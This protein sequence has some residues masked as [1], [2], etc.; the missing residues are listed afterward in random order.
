MHGL[1]VGRV[2]QVGDGARHLQRPVRRTGAP[3]QLGGGRLQEAQGGVVECGMP[4]DRGALQGLVGRALPI[5]GARS[6]RFHPGA[7]GSRGFARRRAQQQ[8]GWQRGHLDVEIDA[9][10]QRS[11]ELALVARHLVGRAAAGTCAGAE[12]AAGAGIH[13]GDQLEARG[14]LGPPRGARDGDGSGLERLAQ[15]LQRGAWKFGQFVEEQHAVVRQRNLAG[16]RRRATADQC[17]R[18]RTV[19]RLARR[20][21][22][23]PRHA[24]ASAQAGDGRAFQRLVDRHGRQQA[25]EAVC[26]HRLARARRPDHEQAVATGRGDLQRALGTGLPLH[27]GQVGVGVG[28]AAGLGL[29]ARPAAAVGRQ[30]LRRLGA[31]RQELRDHV[32]QVPRAVHLGARHQGGLACTVAGQHEPGGDATAVQGQRHGQR[33][34]HRPQLARQGQLAGEFVARESRRIDLTARR[35][36]AHRNRQIEAPRVLG[37]V[38]W[39]QVDRDPL[40]VRKLQARVLQRR[41]HPLAGFLDLH[42]GQS[43]QRE[44]GQSIGQM[45]LDGDTGG[46]QAEERATLHQRQTHFAPYPQNSAVP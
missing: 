15:C 26:Q 17:H 37:Q 8:L 40:V 38:G 24:E 18:A 7:D 21:H 13:R 20:A 22:P 46:V 32:E 16:S 29:H 45:H 35:Q 31:G 3:A 25:G 6:G 19:V 10:E 5:D 9:V 23:P 1:H 33:A 30:R 28:R 27:V 4:V 36:D 43:D 34:A 42:V 12:K 39:R 41:A 2:G 14:K 44:A 11:A